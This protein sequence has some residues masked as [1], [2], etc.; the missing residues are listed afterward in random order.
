MPF[1]FSAGA[2][3]Q[4]LINPR[5]SDVE[6][7]S[8]IELQNEF[9]KKFGGTDY[10]LVPSS[11]SSKKFDESVKLICLHRD[12]VL[13]SAR[14][15][16][17]YFT[18][19]PENHWGLVLPKFHVAGLGTYARAHLSGAKVFE[20]ETEPLINF[21]SMV[22]AQVFDLVSKKKKP[23]PALKKVLVG[24]GWLNSEIK[25]QAITFGWP[26]FETYGMTETASMVAI[27]QND[28]LT[29]LPGVDFE[30]ENKYLKIKCNSLLTAIIQKKQNG[31]Q[32]SQPVK[33]GFYLSEDLAEVSG[34]Q[35]ILKG[36][37][38]EFIKILGEGVSIA[39]LKEIFE[40]L[41]IKRSIPAIRAVLLPVE[42]K[43]RGY[44]LILAVEKS[45]DSETIKQVVQEFNQKV[46]PYEKIQR[47]VAVQRIPHS[48]LG[49]IKTQELKELVLQT[50]QAENSK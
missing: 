38:T 21:I 3:N 39:E 35:L 10:F 50:M 47:T 24:A 22:P 17:S 19:G 14:R 37:A 36:R 29:A 31:I 16:N 11:G 48:E 15:F 28:V 44:D 5:L 40:V 7:N 23:W 34:D 30:T 46:R 26:L 49:K 8:I 20:N 1:D 12:A 9:E 25:S 27:K 43:R 32:I 4:L 41:A 42:Q 2:K 13:N 18:A 33:E 6:R 45:V